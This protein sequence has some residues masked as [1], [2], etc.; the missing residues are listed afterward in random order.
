MVNQNLGYAK[1][2]QVLSMVGPYFVKVLVQTGT[3]VP[4]K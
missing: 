1:H 2:C 4:V 3:L